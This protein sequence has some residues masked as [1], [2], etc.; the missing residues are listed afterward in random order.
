MRGFDGER[1]GGSIG[2]GLTA[3]SG[4]CDISVLAT[5]NAGKG[6][7]NGIG[8]TYTE[9]TLR[10]GNGLCL[11]A[12]RDTMLTGVQMRGDSEKAGTGRNLTLIPRSL[13]QSAAEHQCGRELHLRLDDRGG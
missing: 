5:L 13:R 12:G 10:A 7:A 6:H 1:T 11:S 3:R 8:L 2:V 4:G 9:T